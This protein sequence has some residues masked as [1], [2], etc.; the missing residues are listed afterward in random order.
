MDADADRDA[1]PG[2]GD[3]LERLQVDLVGLPGAADLLRVRH[4]EEA[5]LAELAEDVARERA[6]GLGL[7]GARRQLGGGDVAGEPD[8]LLGLGG[9]QV[10]LGGHGGRRH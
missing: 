8:D 4:P 5:E 7:R 2:A 3:L 9:G 1:R 6:V 10:A